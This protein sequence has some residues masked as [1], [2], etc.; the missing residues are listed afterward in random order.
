L[1]ARVPTLAVALGRDAFTGMAAA[2]EARYPND[3]WQ[4]PGYLAA[5][6]RYPLWYAEVAAIDRARAE[7]KAAPRARRMS[8]A[9]VA[10]TRDLGTLRIALV[11]AHAM[12]SLTTSADELW[13]AIDAG[14]PVLD[15]PDELDWPRTVLVWRASDRLSTRT[16][17]HDE[18]AALH[19]A[20]KGAALD[21]L[22][23]TFASFARALDVMLRWIEDGVIAG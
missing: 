6:L 23:A 15:A 8:R 7:V 9:H 4:L 1:Q 21:E 13:A 3:P 17:A 11:P 18:I 16:V 22:A 12:V 20:T 2:Y 10:G 14:H 5:S 19:A